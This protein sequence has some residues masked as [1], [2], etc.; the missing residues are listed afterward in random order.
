MSKKKNILMVLESQVDKIVLGV[1][2]L[3]SLVLLWLYVI[4]N[5]Y[6]E[7]VRIGGREVSVKPGDIDRK[8][9]DE[10]DGLL[11]GL[12]QPPQ[13]SEYSVYEKTYLADYS[14]KMQ[15]AIAN[16]PSD[17]FIPYPGV[18]ETAIEEDR[19]YA[20]PSIPSLTDV[21]TAVVRGAAQVPVQEVTPGMPY[22]S[23][24]TKPTDI[25]FV[26]VS[27]HFDLQ[28]LYNNF[29]L[30]FANPA[31]KSSWKDNRLATPVLARVEL[32]RRVKMENGTFGEW[33]D[34]PRAKIDPYKKLLE[35]LPL[36]ADQM[37]FGVDVW[38]S[39]YQS[40]EV[41]LDILQPASYV[42]VV[43]RTEWMP[44]EY[45]IETF[46]ILQKQS[47][48]QKREA[49]EERRKARET[50]RGIERR[51]ATGRQPAATPG[52]PAITDPRMM[53]IET[54]RE[55]PITRKERTLQDV[56]KDMQDAMLAKGTRLDNMR[57]PVLI[58]AHDDTVQPGQTYEYRIRIGAFNPITG[59]DWFQK[60]QLAFKDQTVLWSDYFEL[61]EAVDIP[62]MLD[63]FPVDILKAKDDSKD[64]N[65]VKVEV[66][67][68]YM[69]KWQTHEFDVYPGET[70]GYS[71]EN[72][73][74]EGTQLTEGFVDMRMATTV[75]TEETEIDYA[76]GI[77]MVDIVKEITWG[78]R[79]RRTDFYNMLCY[80]VNGLT[81]IGVGKSNWSA[82]LK[83][84]YS[85]IQ[86]AMEQDVQT[87][88]G[89]M[90]DPRRM[91][92]DPRKRPL[93]EGLP[94]EFF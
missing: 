43:S 74:E 47:E 62:K 93:E 65:G 70:I 5:P 81:Q 2:V 87:R 17:I 13:S 58:W 29:Q 48:Q 15:C 52:R 42:F 91:L 83:K 11:E 23:V 88:D 49:I 38:M 41:Q 77:T 7:K 76:S 64:I 12:E 6:G 85:T 56:E 16:V 55:R 82:S 57:E 31:L 80:G 67:K 30:S 69:G 94:P 4:G 27:A 61:T 22:E 33:S 24:E 32:Q 53:G 84:S 1:I 50:E 19:L 68:Y 37:Q 51:P 89:L 36:Q 92:T 75:T 14:Q 8:V 34:V 78:T 40:E 71:V 25:D 59:K 72:T 90:S 46:E 86:D 73:P 44:P 39:Q 3:I 54:V 79:M 10:A 63:I 26:T 45:L 60:D 18:G 35:Q 20:I 66:A 21:K 28:R 9:K